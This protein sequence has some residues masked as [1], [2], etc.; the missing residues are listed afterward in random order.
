MSIQTTDELRGSMLPQL[1][2]FLAADG[3][4]LIDADG[5]VIDSH[6]VDE[7]VVS[8]AAARFADPEARARKREQL[9][10]G[11]VQR[12]RPVLPM[13]LGP[14]TLLVWVNP[15][16]PFFGPDEL[17][18][19]RTAGTTFA[20]TL[21]RV[22]MLEQMQERADRLEEVG[23]LKDEFVAMAS[24]E[25]RTP[26]TSIL[27]FSQTMRDMPERLT[28]EQHAQF[29]GIIF[30]QATRLKRM[31]EDMLTLAQ[32]EEG[33]LK[34]LPERIKL[35][36]AIEHALL[37]ISFVGAEIDCDP[38]L[39]VYADP[40]HLHQMLVNYLTNA[41]RHGAGPYRIVAYPGSAAACLGPE[42]SPACA[43][44]CVHIAVEDAGEG[45]AKQFLP[46]LF[47]RFSQARTGA[48]GAGTGLGLA[49]VRQM[50]RAQGGEAWYE[51]RAGGGSRFGV[52]L[53]A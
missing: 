32:I 36:P 31:V 29:N 48:S 11:K 28:P 22:R 24:H 6:G 23:R 52:S 16:L 37:A 17:Q 15:Y 18:L 39:S 43:G 27:G 19:I 12:E 50:A 14:H 44:G 4:A 42:A 2:R 49:I 3:I 21:E 13:E 10:R 20:L 5:T 33:E 8:E 7:A 25:L 40:H 35:R 38:E 26:L 51:P 9:A 47:D 1:A 30:D 46:R 53:P 34:V 41:E 45:I